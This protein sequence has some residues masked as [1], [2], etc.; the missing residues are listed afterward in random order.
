M[1][2]FKDELKKSAGVM[3]TSQSDLQ[4]LQK[5]FDYCVQRMFDVNFRY[6]A[7]KN[8]ILTKEKSGKYEYIH[9]QKY[10][11][12]YMHI[13]RYFRF[14]EKLSEQQEVYLKEFNGVSIGGQTISQYFSKIYPD[15]KFFLS[16][17]W[18]YRAYFTYESFSEKS[19]SGFFGN[20]H[21]FYINER[22]KNFL[23]KLKELAA[24]DDIN[25]EFYFDVDGQKITDGGSFKQKAGGTM[26]PTVKLVIRYSV[27]F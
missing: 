19:R 12:G 10:V 22:L 14:C 6:R 7:I 16:C 25:I 8:E 27:Q 17:D 18:D 11:S 4:D 23:I 3:V 26:P 15:I 24:K 1:Y 13:D 9:G 20:Y 2:S 5:C 21:Y